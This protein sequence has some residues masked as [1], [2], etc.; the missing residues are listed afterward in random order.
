M[1]F[2]ICT[3][4]TTENVCQ[5]WGLEVKAKVAQEGEEREEEK[6]EG[7]EGPPIKL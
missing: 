7:L 2:G 4:Q 5:M 6:N 3:L 1:H